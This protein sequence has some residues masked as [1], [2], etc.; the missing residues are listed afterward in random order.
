MVDSDF[1][2]VFGGVLCI[3]FSG[4][5]QKALSLYQDNYPLL[6]YS[7]KNGMQIDLL[8]NEA[9]YKDALPLYMFYSTG[10]S[11]INEQMKNNPG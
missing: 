11:D 7:N 2:Y 9:K 1:G 6:S 5:G 4:T 8:I 3:P 10:E